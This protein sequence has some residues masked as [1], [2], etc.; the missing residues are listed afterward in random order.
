ME[1]KKN[2]GSVNPEHFRNFKPELG[3]SSPGRI[4]MIG[5]HTDY[6]N[7]FV[8][9]TAIDRTIELNFA[10][11]SSDFECNVYSK[12]Y[13]KH[14]SFDLRKISRSE[15]AWENYIL[16]VVVEIQKRGKSLKGFDCVITSDLPVGAGVSS[17]AALECG[18][19]FGLNELFKLGLDR[20]TMAQLSQSAEHHY[21]GTKCGIMD[22]Y[23]SMLSKKD[24]LILLDC[25]S[26]EAS[27]VP[28]Q[29]KEYQ[30]LLLNTMVSHK[31]ADSEYN[32]R[33]AECEKVVEVVQKK[34]PEVSS[35]RDVSF[36]ILED[37]KNELSE[38]QY[39][40]A[41]YV[42]EEND[43][44]LR[45]VD[46]IQEGRID[47]FGSLMYASH[48]GLRDEYEVSCKELDFLVDFTKTYDYIS[49]ARM[50][51]GG[52]GGCTINLIKNEKVEEFT[53]KAAAAYS[54][55][56]GIELQAIPVLPQEGTKIKTA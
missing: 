38:V 17:S 3:I 32:K 25:K 31:L 2:T 28:A 44:V 15:K 19:A 45:A 13:N 18:M 48:A 51:G 27:Y 4:N 26:L 1:K 11:N 50:M 20:K 33:R 41:H 37:V 42:L 9:P 39:K 53:R 24:H 16:G 43:R 40:R 7:G 49:G 30:V 10:P 21:V 55:A 5:E 23:A 46:A 29:F 56:F 34:Y 14:F 52:F 54:E 6:N 22:Q 12:T 8:L 36:D 35:L 47:D